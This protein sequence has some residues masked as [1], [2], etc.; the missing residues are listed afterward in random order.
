[1]SVHHIHER[2]VLSNLL[3]SAINIVQMRPILLHQHT[4]LKCSP[5][6]AHPLRTQHAQSRRSGPHT[7]LTALAISE[8]SGRSFLSGPIDGQFRQALTLYPTVFPLDADFEVEI[9]PLTVPLQ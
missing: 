5:G 6:Y 9:S 3:Y 2:V 8:I 1:M 7:P 4:S